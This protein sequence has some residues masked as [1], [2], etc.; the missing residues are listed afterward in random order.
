MSSP[1]I[2]IEDCCQPTITARHITYIGQGHLQNPRIDCKWQKALQGVRKS[3][4]SEPARKNLWRA[5]Q[6]PCVNLKLVAVYIIIKSSQHHNIA[7]WPSK[8]PKLQ[9]NISAWVSHHLYRMS[10]QGSVSQVV[11]LEPQTLLCH[12]NP[13]PSHSEPISL[14]SYTF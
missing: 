13:S 3:V 7:W 14:I 5:N 10:K 2:Q 4:H 11:N 1:R 9:A 6:Q 8:R 12:L